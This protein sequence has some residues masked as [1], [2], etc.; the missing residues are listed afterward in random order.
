[1]AFPASRLL[2]VVSATPL[3]ASLGWR[4]LAPVALA[5]AILTPLILWKIPT[6]FLPILLG[7]YLVAHFLVYGL[8]TLAG[9][10]FLG[11]LGRGR[12]GPAPSRVGLAV[13][14]AALAGYYVIAMGL[15][16]DAYAT[17]FMP[18][19]LRWLLIPA[20]F[21]GT[22]IYFLADEWLTRGVGA[23]WGGYAFSK[24]CFLVSLVVAVALNPEKLFFLVLIV[25]VICVLFMI[26]GLL[27]RWVY[28]RTRDPRVGA[29]GSAF[30]LAWAIAVTF[31]IV[32]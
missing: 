3:G 7:D 29:L 23:A 10:W 4:R 32:G 5:P 1:L 28:S 18:T 20:M 19:G 11:G 21:C 31:P 26:Y 16:I 12:A 17:S 27:S 15:P 30:G 2:P 22:A 14:G 9:L 24:L 25:P 6:D 13:G 8:L